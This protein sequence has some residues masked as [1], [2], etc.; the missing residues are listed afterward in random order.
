MP[1]LFKENDT[2][3]GDSGPMSL[4]VWRENGEVKYQS[5]KPVVGRAIRVGTPA[6][7][8]YASQDWW[9]TSLV[10]E[11]LEEQEDYV[12]FRTYSGSIYIWRA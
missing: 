3:R 8:T 5:G 6:K 7:R 1:K 9:Q 4:Q 11:I 10:T 2:S 12:K